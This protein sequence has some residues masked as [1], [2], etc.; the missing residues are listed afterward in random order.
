MPDR[1][2]PLKTILPFGLHLVSLL[3]ELFIHRLQHGACLFDVFT[4]LFAKEQGLGRCFEKFVDLFV[5]E[6]SE[7]RSRLRFK[8]E[9][10][11]QFCLIGD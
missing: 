6:V 9:R 8:F 7:L 4:H 2:G 1:V 5:A 11:V 10:L 3:P